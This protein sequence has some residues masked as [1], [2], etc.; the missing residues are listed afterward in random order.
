MR[1]DLV[2]HIQPGVATN[3]GLNVL[4]LLRH[5]T[6]A[7]SPLPRLAASGYTKPSTVYFSYLG[8]FFAYSFDAALAAYGALAGAALLYVWLVGAG[9]RGDEPAHEKAN[10]RAVPNGSAPR[11][12]LAN[13]LT[14]RPPAP[15]ARPRPVLTALLALSSSLLLTL[16]LPNLAAL[17]LASPALLNKSMSWFASEYAVVPLFAPPALLGA[18]S[19]HLLVAPHCLAAYSPA[20]MERLT[21]HAVLVALSAGAA[22]VQ[23]L[24]VGSAAILFLNAAPLLLV[25]LL[26]R[27][28]APA[29]SAGAAF[30][31][32]VYALAQ[33]SP[34]LGGTMLLTPVVEFFV[35]LTGRIGAGPVPADNILATI[36][37]AVLALALPLALPFLYRF[38]RAQVWRGWV[39]VLLLAGAALAVFV[40]REAFDGMHQRRVF[41]LWREEAGVG[42]RSLHVAGADGAPGLGALVGDIARAFGDP[43]VFRA[44]GAGAGAEVL[45]PRAMDEYNSDWDTLYPFSS[46]RGCLAF[47]CGANTGCSF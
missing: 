43:E 33:W 37:A 35:P 34:L 14:V 42:A 15:T 5:L 4:A 11:K 12:P 38:E 21:M 22:G 47:V 23:A 32:W 16:L 36:V 9:P 27:L 7:A 19:A 13:G 8:W 45:V 41:V 31:T 25:L 40:G 6:S 20:Q 17:L 24:R 39:R 30:P 10:G 29:P 44:G 1:K 26:A 28:L 2:Q 46:V 18:L 3:M